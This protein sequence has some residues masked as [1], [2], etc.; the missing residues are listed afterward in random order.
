M[1]NFKD[2]ISY[3]LNRMF[4]KRQKV[5]TLGMILL[6]SLFWFSFAFFATFLIQYVEATSRTDIIKGQ[7]FDY[8]EY[9]GYRYSYCKL[10][11]KM[12]DNS[13]KQIESSVCT[14]SMYENKSADVTIWSKPDLMRIGKVAIYKMIRDDG[15]EIYKFDDENILRYK[16]LI[17][18]SLI[19]SIMFLILFYKFNTSEDVKK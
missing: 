13:F 18:Y 17:L 10:K 3:V 15:F 4:F 12:R 5:P 7:L 14:W 6:Q 11:L 16:K 8:E 1:E 19:V 9:R 2:K